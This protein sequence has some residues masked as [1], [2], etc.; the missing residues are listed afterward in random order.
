R[1]HPD[2]PSFPTRRS[3]DLER[4]LDER[5]RLLTHLVRAQEEERRRI[6]WD[7]HDDTIQSM[8][9]VGMRLQLLAAALPAEH[10]EAVLRLND[11]VGDRKSTRLNSSH[12]KISY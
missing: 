11:T 2:L 6:A 3:S 5:G 10:A 4:A 12:V 7:V 8:V 1:A 9:A